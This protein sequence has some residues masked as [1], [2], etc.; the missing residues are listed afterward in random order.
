MYKLG[1]KKTCYD[2]W[3]TYPIKKNISPKLGFTK[4]FHIIFNDLLEIA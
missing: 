3:Y 2:N 1:Q 4:E